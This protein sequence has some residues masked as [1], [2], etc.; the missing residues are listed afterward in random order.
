MNLTP[1]LFEDR[2]RAANA[3]LLADFAI[4]AERA[5]FLMRCALIAA[6]A[7]SRLLSGPRAT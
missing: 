7:A 5:G 4:K 3:I 2:L 6:C 1:V